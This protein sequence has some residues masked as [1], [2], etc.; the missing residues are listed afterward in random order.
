MAAIL[1]FT[2]SQIISDSK[3]D[4]LAAHYKPL[5]ALINKIETLLLKTWKQ[6]TATAPKARNQSEQSN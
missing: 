3:H 4:T 2:M 1:F 6:V 5:E